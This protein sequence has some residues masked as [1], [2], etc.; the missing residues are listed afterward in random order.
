MAKK[1]V[2]HKCYDCLKA[3]LMQWADDPIIAECSQTGERE[4]ANYPNGCTL[5]KQ[6]TKEP[7]IEHYKKRIGITDIYI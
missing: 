7:E 3:K 5:F 6:N 1:V 2:V 4:V